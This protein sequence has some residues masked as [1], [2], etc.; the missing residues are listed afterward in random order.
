MDLRDLAWMVRHLDEPVSSVHLFPDGGLIAG[1]WNGCVKRW[2]EQGELLWT[3]STP[4]RVM[5]VTPWGDALALTA[6]L[7]VVVLNLDTGEERWSRPLEGSADLQCVVGEHLLT[8]SS[9]YDIEHFDFLESALWLHDASGEEVHVHRLDERPWDVIEHDGE[10]LF[11]LGRPR[12]G[13]LVTKDGR[14]FEHRAINDAAVLAMAHDA[15]GPLVLSSVGDLLRLSG[16]GMDGMAQ[17][18]AMH[19]GAGR[20]FLSDEAG[21]FACI[22]EGVLWAVPGAPIT[23]AGVLAGQNGFVAVARW[24]GTQGHLHMLEADGEVL[25]TFDVKRV[26]DMDAHGQRLAVGMD[27]G[28]VVVLDA[29]MLRRRFGQNTPPESGDD[30]AAAHRAAMLAKLRALRT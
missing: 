29:A 8:T 20:L 10:L 14:T 23:A 27:D 5:A 6:G 1:G 26:E 4:D 2:D 12:G 22:E 24:S 7:H 19:T 17:A 21:N 13:L 28:N 16:E 18:D 15:E 11:G 30:D 9:V 3:A 25:A